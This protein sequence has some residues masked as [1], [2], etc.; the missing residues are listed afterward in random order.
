MLVE[1]TRVF[2]DP[3]PGFDTGDRRVADDQPILGIDTLAEQPQKKRKHKDTDS[4]SFHAISL[5]RH[6]FSYTL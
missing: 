1:N 6:E 4:L 5:F 2:S 3:K